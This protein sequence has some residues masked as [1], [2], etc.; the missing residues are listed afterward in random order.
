VLRNIL[1]ELCATGALT[2]LALIVVPQHPAAAIAAV[3]VAWIGFQLSGAYAFM[4]ALYHGD[5][6]EYPTEPRSYSIAPHGHA[7]ALARRFMRSYLRV[8]NARPPETPPA[9]E[10]SR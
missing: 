5:I 8:A 3:V 4:K 2:A 7:G 10:D 6:V 1:A 9:V